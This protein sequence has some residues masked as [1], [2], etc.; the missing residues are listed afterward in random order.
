MGNG[1]EI[2]VSPTIT[3]ETVLPDGD[4]GYERAKKVEEYLRSC[5]PSFKIGSLKWDV[6]DGETKHPPDYY[7]LSI[8]TP[9]PEEIRKLVKEL[10]EKI[11]NF[12]RSLD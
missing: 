4:K 6:G 12:L 11:S 8:E 7:N 9:L 1:F 3:I 2:L 5:Y 10:K